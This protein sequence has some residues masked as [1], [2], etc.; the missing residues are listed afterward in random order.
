ME[1]QIVSV[2][3]YPYSRAQLLKGRL[4]AEGIE[5]FLSNVNLVQPGIATGVKI[6]VAKADVEKALIIIEEIKSEYGEAKAKTVDR[7]KSVRRVLV[8]IDFSE[9]SHNACVFALGL[10]QRLKAEIR[11]LYVYFNPILSSEP[12]D[13]TFSYQISLNNVVNDL[14]KEAKDQ[15]LKLK[16]LLKKRIEKEKFNKVRISYHLAKG[17]PEDVIL[18][19]C[20]TYQ[21]GVVVMGTRGKGGRMTEF[22]GSVTKKV[23]EKAK[24]PVLAIPEHSV[25]LGINYINRLIYATDFSESDFKSIRK[26]ITMVRPFDM[27]VYCVHICQDSDNPLDKV[28]MESLK[29]HFENEYGDCEVFCDLIEN[30]DVAK[31]LEEYIDEK[32]MDM[33][34]MTLSKRGLIERLF[35]PSLT[36]KMFYHSEIPLLVFHS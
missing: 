9:H 10:A 7:I 16:K 22:F 17:I 36:K 19:H 23:I 31:G 12:Y 30:N 11:L 3:S 20:E 35:N 15:I 21:P 8:P 27:K 14:E 34:A 1:D 33:L 24:V 2:A 25:F 6:R 26:L 28:K 4:E 5:C 32:D 13:E 29:K 18:E